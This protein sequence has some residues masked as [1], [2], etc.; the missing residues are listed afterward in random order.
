MKILL[1][2][3]LLLVSCGGGSKFSDQEDDNTIRKKHL[4]ETLTA[5][6]GLYFKVHT[7]STMSK[8][9]YMVLA[10]ETVEEITNKMKLDYLL[11]L[12]AYLQDDQRL[13]RYGDIIL[14]PYFQKKMIIKAM[15][16][17]SKD[18]DSIECP[19]EI[20]ASSLDFKKPKKVSK[21]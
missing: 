5:T 20:L 15:I 16:K 21:K 10:C 2:G 12:L 1:L 19:S 9:E 14:T 17:L 8:V 3:L 13:T 7:E 6:D 18:L 4:V 11:D